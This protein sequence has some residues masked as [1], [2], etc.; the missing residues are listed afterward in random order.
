MIPLSSARQLL[1]LRTTVAA[2]GP[3]A[4]ANAA[5]RRTLAGF[6][7]RFDWALD[8]LP[9]RTSDIVCADEVSAGPPSRTGERELRIGWICA[10]PGP[11]SGGHTTLF[12]MVEAAEERGHQCTLFLY[13]RNS[14]DVARHELQVRAWWPRLKANVRSATDGMQG[15]HAL[16]ASSWGTAHVLA[17]RR[18]PET[19]CL[20]F[21]QDF[22]PYFYPRGALY[23]LAEDTYRFGFTNI[24]LGSMVETTLKIEVGKAP[25]ATVPFGCDTTTYKLLP[26][27]A[28]T[29]RH[30]IVYYAKRSVDRRGYLLAKLALE[31][32]HKLHP[33]QQIHI[34]G[35]VL[36]SWDVPV[37]NHGTLSPAELNKL[38]N[39]TIASIAISF[40]NVTLVV[41][42]MMAAGN[43]P[44][45]NDHPFSRAVL[46]ARGPVWVPPTPLGLA[47]GLSAAV[48]AN[49]VATRAS[50]L[51]NL[52]RKS[53]H[54]TG[55]QVAETIE[56]ACWESGGRETGLFMGRDQ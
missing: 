55:T 4:A 41:E 3:R 35:D 14:D 48:T 44:V 38:Y 45:I 1:R 24:A 47:S 13:D 8:S 40:T 31:A 43:V 32:F 30:G 42:E 39:S 46:D 18:P 25:E 37:I 36:S 22:E 5:V 50:E 19:Q 56:N 11:G 49:N 21:I 20:Y 17:R 9:I 10:P 53:W 29:P 34:V 6:S 52:E 12:R 26:E 33:E 15:M 2:M 27:S 54:A 28:K 51:A 23:A 7:N 16:V